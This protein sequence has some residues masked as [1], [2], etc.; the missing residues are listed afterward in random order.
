MPILC[1]ISILRRGTLRLGGILDDV[2]RVAGAFGVISNA[3]SLL[4]ERWVPV[5]ANRFKLPLDACP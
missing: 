1:D 4:L 5:V 2:G 3:F